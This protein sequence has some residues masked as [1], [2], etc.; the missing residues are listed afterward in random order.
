MQASWAGREQLIVNDGSR[1]DVRPFLL[2]S[3]G[4]GALPVDN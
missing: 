2:L 3:Q 1:S 4:A